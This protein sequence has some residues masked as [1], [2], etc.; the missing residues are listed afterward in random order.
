MA[1]VLALA[2]TAL[3]LPRARA[4]D[5]AAE[6]EVEERAYLD[7]TVG[8][9]SAG[10]QAAEVQE[11]SAH[12]HRA[13]LDVTVGAVSAGAQ[14]AEVQE[15]SAHGHR[16]YL[17]V[18]VGALSAVAS[19]QALEELYDGARPKGARRRARERAL[20]AQ[21]A[22][23]VAKTG[24]AQLGGD[25]WFADA[26]GEMF[27]VKQDRCSITFPLKTRNGKVEKRGVVRGASVLVEPPFPEGTVVGA[28]VKFENG[29]QWERKW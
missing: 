19:D 8:A 21:T 28:S 12:D 3:A 22:E 4:V 10:A 14:A 6:T 16:A 13:Y 1:R 29:A 27:Q 2:L 25:R 20:A 9:V 5:S 11:L 7:V 15:L 18:T 24:C 23:D 17:D 26:H